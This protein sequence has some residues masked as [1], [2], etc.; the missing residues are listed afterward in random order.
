MAMVVGCVLRVDV[1]LQEEGEKTQQ[2]GAKIDCY[3]NGL[4]MV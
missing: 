4:T 2:C 1:V 3:G